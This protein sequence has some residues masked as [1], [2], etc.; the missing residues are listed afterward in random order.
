MSQTRREKLLAA[1][2]YA[3]LAAAAERAGSWDAEAVLAAMDR[4]VIDSMWLGLG[5]MTEVEAVQAAV[6]Y[7]N[8]P[9][10]WL[11][12]ST[13]RREVRRATTASERRSRDAERKRRQRASMTDQEREAHRAR[14][15]ERKRRARVP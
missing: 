9:A 1:P 2:L 8:D 10:G 6:L 7:L 5:R 13:A 3:E 12:W 15:R 4:S 14:D 11:E